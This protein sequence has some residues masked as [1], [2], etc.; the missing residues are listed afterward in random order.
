MY[1]KI[2]CFILCSLPVYASETSIFDQYHSSLCEVLLE[3]SNE[4]DNYFIDGNQTE[5]S[6]TDAEII[7]SVAYET[8]KLGFES[9][10]RVRLR[11]D[12]PKIEKNLR[13]VFEDESS[14]NLL[15]DGTSLENQQLKDKEYYLRLEYFNYIR[16][17]FNLRLGGGVKIR[18]SNLVPYLTTRMKYYLV[19]SDTSKMEFFNRLRY[20]TDGEV[21]NNF[22]FN[23]LFNIQP[24]VYLINRN[25]Y[26]YSN[27]NTFQTLANDVSMLHMLNEKQYIRYG[28][29]LSN[30]VDGFQ[31]SSVDY[32]HVHSAWHHLFYK[33]VLYYE[34]VPSILQ[35][36]VND[37]QT[38][39]RLLVNFGIYFN[40]YK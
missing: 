34:V 22:E 10:L 30:H 3:T 5:K 37:F 18:E 4:I 8:K 36:R 20:Y 6:K 1:Q 40:K 19:K 2:L 12:L 7:T 24:D 31:S 11:L 33:N 38:S 27:D 26:Y 21:E 35:R 17:Q 9:D 32:Y 16:E 13:L 39:Y 15:Y 25:N 14:D 23:S 28:I 29:G